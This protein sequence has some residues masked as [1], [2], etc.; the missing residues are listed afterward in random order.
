MKTLKLRDWYFH[1]AA[2]W[3]FWYPQSGIIGGLIILMITWILILL[4]ASTGVGQ[5]TIKFA[6]QSTER[7][8]AI[9]YQQADGTIVMK[10]TPCEADTTI[11]ID[12]DSVGTTIIPTQILEPKDHAPPR[13]WE[14]A[15]KWERKY[16]KNPERPIYPSDL[17]RFLEECWNDS[18]RHD[19]LEPCYSLVYPPCKGHPYDPPRYYYTHRLENA[20][21]ME[22][23]RAF[24]QWLRGKR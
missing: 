16:G 21:A 1:P 8:R 3:Q 2:W 19:E 22:V 15:A 10:V 18:T 5:E 6:P 4:F 14:G 7:E 23:L 17:S 20:S 24:Q 9:V 11:D 12:I 13:M